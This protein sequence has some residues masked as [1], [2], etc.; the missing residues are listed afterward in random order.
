[1]GFPGG[2]VVTNTPTNAGDQGSIPGSERSPGGG[3]GSPFQYFCLQNAM[4]RGAWRGYGLRGD[5]ASDSPEPARTHCSCFMCC[6]FYFI[7]F[8]L[9]VYEILASLPGIKPTSLTLEGRVLTTGPPS[10]APPRPAP[11]SP[12]MPE[13]LLCGT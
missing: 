2:S 11:G 10:Q 3:N 4:H 1:M 12:L 9:E 5:R 7:F 8:A 6:L 13:F